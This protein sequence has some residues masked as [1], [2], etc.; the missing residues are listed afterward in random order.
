[1]STFLHIPK[2]GGTA[3]RNAL[4]TN[5]VAARPFTVALTHGSNIVNTQ[6][7]IYFGLRDPL[8]R[9]CS[10][11][12]ERYTNPMRKELNKSAPN[13]FRGSGYRDFNDIEKYVF[14]MY[15]TPNAML[16]SLRKKTYPQQRYNI[17]DTDL[18]ILLAPLTAWIGDVNTLRKHENRV[19]AVFDVSNLT[20]IMKTMYGIDM[21]SDPFLKRSRDQF[22][23]L[24]QSYDV[25]EEN[26]V[27]FKEHFR[28]ADYDVVD[29]I[30]KQSYYIHS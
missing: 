15:P 29:Y 22:P 12:W 25:S 21:P 10:G 6:M 1:M 19:G 16:T 4:L 7:Q 2:T 9:F 20:Q 11:F 14:N 8:E 28:K 24:E 26:A 18:N 3:L 17:K 23:E 5:N 27:W 13:M 30:K